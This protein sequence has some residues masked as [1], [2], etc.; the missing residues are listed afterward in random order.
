MS[1]KALDTFA[2]ALHYSHYGNNDHA[3]GN[4]MSP[5]AAPAAALDIRRKTSAEAE[6]QTERVARIAYAVL[7]AVG[8]EMSR[9][10]V[11]RIVRSFE[12]RVAGNGWSFFDYFANRIQL[13]SERRRQLLSDPDVLRVIAYADPTGE[14]AVRNVMRGSS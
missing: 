11:S 2:R 10:K 1:R 8:Y 7:D 13:D 12:A 9:A 14:T 5:G 6:S 3:S 4:R